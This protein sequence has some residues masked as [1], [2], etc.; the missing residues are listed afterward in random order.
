MKNKLSFLIDNISNRLEL[1]G[2]IKYAYGL[3][4]IANTLDKTSNT[5]YRNPEMY[6]QKNKSLEDLVKY[7]Y[8]DHNKIMTPNKMYVMYGFEKPADWIAKTLGIPLSKVEEAIKSEEEDNSRKTKELNTRREDL[9]NDLKNRI[10][11]NDVKALLKGRHYNFSNEDWYKKKENEIL[12]KWKPYASKLV[13][14][15]DEDSRNAFLWVTNKK[16]WD[17]I[18]ECPFVADKWK[19]EVKEDIEKENKNKINVGDLLSGTLRPGRKG[20]PIL[21]NTGKNHPIIVV[22]QA[23]KDQILKRTTVKIKRVL[24]NIIISDYV[25]SE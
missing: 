13:D 15:V 25:S 18:L 24:D 8:D 22:K 2:F 4:I 1:R 16:H 17:W 20:D 21:T 19:N 9:K 14:L 23:P 12:G 6:G 7:Q 11:Q 3:D 10:M 5:F